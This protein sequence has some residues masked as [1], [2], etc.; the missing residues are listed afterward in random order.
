[1]KS[2]RIK[3]IGRLDDEMLLRSLEAFKPSS[4]GSNEILLFSDYSEFDIPIGYSFDEIVS[5][6]GVRTVSGK[7]KLIGVTQQMQVAFDE[8]P[9]G[10]KTIC[11]FV[12]LDGIPDIISDLPLLKNWEHTDQY[13]YFQ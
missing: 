11:R 12:F 7:I 2:I 13:L 10:W 6:S 5:E 1:M 9:K 8:V 3:I 4:L